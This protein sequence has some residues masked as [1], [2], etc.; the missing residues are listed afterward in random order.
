MPEWMSA[1]PWIVFAVTLGVALIAAVVLVALV[2]LPLRL[3]SRRSHGDPA[4]LGRLRRP[5]R[6]LVLVV[7]L[8][9][10]ATTALPP[11][12]AEWRGGI[13]HGLGIAGIVATGWLIAGV[14]GFAFARTLRR[15][16]TDV[17]DNRIARRVHTQIAILRRLLYVVIAIVTVGAVL[18]TFPG[19]QGV[20]ASLLASAGVLS[21][22][23]GIAAQSTLAN[24]F[25][26]VQL[27]FS[28]ALRVDDVV[29]VEDEWGRIE[30]I[31]LTYVVVHIWDDRRLVLPST[32]F[33]STPFQ[34]WTRRTS[35]LLG[36]VE[37]DVDWQV[38]VD[39]MR[40]RLAEVLEEQPLWDRRAS[41]LQVTDATGDRVRI[42]ILVTAKDAPTLF[43]LR[44]NVREEMVEWVRD[45]H[46]AALPRTRVTM[47]DAAPPKTRAPRAPKPHEG[48]FSGSTE[49]EERASAFT[50]A[51]P[52]PLEGEVPGGSGR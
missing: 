27:A 52:L 36:S 32:Y 33:T 19:V 14:V 34:N 10:V 35:D 43:D 26:G 46:P 7:A 49:A 22:V 5:F 42:R 41:V 38:P 31:T 23:A 4:L 44:C 40:E 16:P 2:T 15:H 45:Q 21:V 28:D 37:L 1:N 50:G 47:V 11:D 17:A 39:A 30:E 13:L 6:A 8:V 29:I 51:I 9:A 24:V 18:L 12:L 20:G 25:A 3:A 48:V